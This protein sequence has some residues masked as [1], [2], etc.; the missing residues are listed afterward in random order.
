M[1]ADKK[2]TG[3]LAACAIVRSESELLSLRAFS[4]FHLRP[5]GVSTKSSQFSPA[6]AV[7]LQFRD[8]SRVAGV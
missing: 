1:D 7:I 6:G 3:D 8:K 5:S 2:S 4:V